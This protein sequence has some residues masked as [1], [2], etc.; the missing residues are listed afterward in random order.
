MRRVL[1]LIGLIAVSGLLAIVGWDF[2]KFSREVPPPG[3]P[4]MRA[5][6]ILVEKQSRRMTLLRDGMPIKIYD[7]SLG[8]DPVGHKQQEGDGRTP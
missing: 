1:I 8:R 3:S 6:S 7:V 5:T 4:D 2:G